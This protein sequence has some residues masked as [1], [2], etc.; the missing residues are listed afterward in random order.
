MIDIIVAGPSDL[1]QNISSRSTGHL[2]NKVI[3]Q[4][5]WNWKT[6]KKY[7][8]LH[9]FFSRFIMYPVAIA[10]HTFHG[11]VMVYD[12]GQLW[13]NISLTK[14][15]TLT[16][17]PSFCW[18]DPC[19]PW[20]TSRGCSHRNKYILLPDPLCSSPLWWINTDRSEEHTSELQSHSDLVCRLLL[21]KKKKTIR[22]THL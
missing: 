18:L 4:H 22:T 13:F 12:L 19:F 6:P 9:N 10:V 7:T 8:P 20:H 11:A 17:H 15:T 14:L 5:N 21:E 16:N 2:W 1:F 3:T